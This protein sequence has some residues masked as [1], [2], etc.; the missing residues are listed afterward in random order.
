MAVRNQ[1]LTAALIAAS[2]PATIEAGQLATTGPH[3]FAPVSLQ[4]VVARTA[5]IAPKPLDVQQSGRT[6]RRDGVMDGLLKGM[7]A[8][9]GLGAGGALLAVK[10]TGGSD[11]VPAVVKN[12]MLFTTV[13][14]AAVGVLLDATR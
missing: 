10:A 12:T 3:I 4:R 5:N 2:L 11:D 6:A 14:G 9:A 7:A 1:V 13:A 8:G